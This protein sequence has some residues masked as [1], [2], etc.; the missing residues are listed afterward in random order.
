MQRKTV[1][2]RLLNTAD[3]TG[4]AHEK[5]KAAMEDEPIDAEFEDLP[6]GVTAEPE[7]EDPEEIA[8][9]MDELGY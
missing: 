9:I 4:T 7:Q 2:R 6:E 5:L 8:D 3:L 1:L